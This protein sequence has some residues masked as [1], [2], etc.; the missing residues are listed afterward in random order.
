MTKYND[1][2]DS[3][4]YYDEDS[5]PAGD[6]HELEYWDNYEDEDDEYEHQYSVVQ[7][8]WDPDELE[9]YAYD[10]AYQGVKKIRKIRSVQSV[11]VAKAK[12]RKH[13]EK[14]RRQQSQAKEKQRQKYYHYGDQ[15]EDEE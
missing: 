9:D 13:W 12:E 5:Y 7:G 15:D 14:K 3:W 10:S 8:N 11:E 6:D 1:Y 4:D 2:I